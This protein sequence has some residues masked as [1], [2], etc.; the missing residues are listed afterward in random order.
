MT[1]SKNKCVRIL[2]PAAILGAGI[3][4]GTVFADAIRPAAAFAQQGGTPTTAPP[5]NAQ[6]DRQENIRLLTS[7]NDRL[8]KIETKLNSGISVKVTEM[9]AVVVKDNK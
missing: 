4:L 5:W 2:T 3:V 7:I 9:P 1:S 8:T 6:Q